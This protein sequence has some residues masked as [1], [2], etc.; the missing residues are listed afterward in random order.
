MET[1]GFWRKLQ[2]DLQLYVSQKLPQ[3]AQIEQKATGV[4]YRSILECR[5]QKAANYLQMGFE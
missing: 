3:M 1:L 2:T 4:L 5:P